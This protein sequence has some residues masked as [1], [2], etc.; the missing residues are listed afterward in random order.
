[1]L[2][3]GVEDGWG[4]QCGCVRALVTVGAGHGGGRLTS[5]AWDFP[6]EDGC[7]EL[8]ETREHPPAQ[9]VRSAGPPGPA[10]GPTGGPF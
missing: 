1:M 2:S 8:L 10:P 6:L 7:T 3:L 9:E 4:F 5:P